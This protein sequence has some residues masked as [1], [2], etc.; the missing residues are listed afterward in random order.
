MDKRRKRFFDK[1]GIGVLKDFDTIMTKNQIRYSVFAGTLLGA[2]REKGFL[3]HDIDIDTMMFYKDYSTKV[4]DVL[5]DSGFHLLRSFDVDEGMNGKEETYIKDGVTIDI[6]FVYEDNDFPTYQCDFKI[7]R[8]SSQKEK[9]VCRGYADVRRL[10]FPV[11]HEIIR[12]P[13]E[14]ISVNAIANYSE[15]LSYR[16]GDDYMIP[17]PCFKDKGDNPN[18][19]MWQGKK[20]VFIEY[21][22]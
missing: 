13:F 17:N 1:N 20:A 14:T 4:R 2:V 7:D 5:F 9:G 3:K 6:F 18:I 8:S 21:E 10:E 16:Y 12:L 22:A 15:W 11:S 19:F